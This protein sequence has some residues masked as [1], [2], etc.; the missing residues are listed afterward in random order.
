MNLQ[1]KPSRRAGSSD[2]AGEW[3][4]DHLTVVGFRRRVGMEFM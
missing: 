1:T 3:P 2:V 4:Q